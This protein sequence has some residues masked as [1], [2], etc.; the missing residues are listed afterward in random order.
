MLTQIGT[1]AGRAAPVSIAMT[2]GTTPVSYTPKYAYVVNNGSNNVSAY[3]IGAGG[4]LAAV[5]GS[6]FAAGSVSL[7][8]TVDPSGQ[9][10]YVV[11]YTSNNVSA[12]TI[13]AGGALAAVAGS[14]FAAGSGPYSVTVDPSGQYAYVANN[15]GNNVSAYTIGAGGAL[16]AVAGSPFAAGT[17]PNSVTVDPSG[18]YAYVA[19]SNS[20]NTFVYSIGAGGMLTQIGTM[21]GRAVPVS[22]AMTQGTTPVSYTPKYAYVANNGGNVSA[23]TLGAG[24]AL[25]AVAG[26]PFAAGTNPAS[27]TTTGTIQ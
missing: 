23:Y 5:A 26:S 13:G 19:N 25:A 11:N 27:V 14:P 22:I 6:P 7:S 21:A 2:Q 1:M 4:A 9:Y 24:G 17:N 12:Y 20:N 10:A 15:G 16:A 3:T 8:V 18:K